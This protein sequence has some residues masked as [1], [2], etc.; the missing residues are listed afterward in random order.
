MKNKEGIFSKVNYNTELETLLDSKEYSDEAKSL[1]LNAVYKVENSYKDYQKIKQSQ[2]TKNDIVEDII[3]AL[4]TNCNAIEILDPKKRQ[5]KVY[6]DKKRKTIN[7][8]PSEVDLLRA[9]YYIKTPYAKNVENIIE[10]AV[11]IAL[12]KGMAINGAEVIRDFNGWSWNNV[13]EDN[14]SKFYNL[15]YQDMILLI[16]ER[17]IE[18]IISQK[19]NVITNLTSK[20]KDIYGEK[21]TEKLVD[22]IKKACTLVYMKRSKKNEEEVNE[23]LEEKKKSMYIMS[24]KSKYI[25]DLNSKN[26]DTIKQIAIIDALLGSK[27]AIKKRYEENKEKYKTFEAF[28]SYLN[29]QKEK[30]QDIVEK[31]KKLINP[32]EYLKNK[33]NIQNEV[34]ILSDISV[35]CVKRNCVYTSFINIQKS[36]IECMYKKISVYDLKK[37]LIQLA[38][39]F[40]Y[41]NYLPIKDKKMYELKELN[42]ELRNLQEKFIIKLCNSRI[43]ERFSKREDLNYQ[44]TKYIFT[45]KILDINKLLIKMEYKDEKLYLNYFDGNNLEHQELINVDSEE[46]GDLLKRTDKKI[47]V[48][49]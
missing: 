45:T 28:K 37:E 30:L 35:C 38:F 9:I 14:D 20:I 5:S 18:N 25:S 24:D 31:N 36:V 1:I 4:E 17:Q 47:R 7:T 33:E 42:I 39:E 11:L 21:K 48:F 43:L 16:G 41:F 49:V 3:N 19:D 13:I 34:K 46:Y 2:K 40:R 15:L 26:N 22:C 27:T 6:I 29:K 23:Y 10:K 12:E 44:I 32:F 8:F